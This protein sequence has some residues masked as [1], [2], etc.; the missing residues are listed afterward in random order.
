MFK[1]PH[2]Q[3]NNQLVLDNVARGIESKRHKFVASSVNDSGS[4]S[5]G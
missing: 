3:F 5:E 1:N 2:F 4:E